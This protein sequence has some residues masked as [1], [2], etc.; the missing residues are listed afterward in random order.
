MR[1]TVAYLRVSSKL[2]TDGNGLDQQ[3]IGIMAWAATSG[4]EIDEWITETATGTTGQREEISDILKRAINGEI[5]CLVIDRMDRL[6]RLLM[7]SETLY[8]S[9]KEAGVEVVLVNQN[10]DDTPMGVAMRQV[11]GVFSE[12]QRSEWLG[13]MRQC[14][15]AAASKRGKFK[16][17]NTP[18]GYVV[19]RAGELAIDPVGATVVRLC[20]QLRKQGKTLVEIQ[21]ALT[22]RRLLTTAGTPIGLGQICKILKREAAYRGIAAFG[23]SQVEV[24]VQVLHPAILE[25]DPPMHVVS[26]RPSN[27][28]VI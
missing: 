7:V 22:A 18:Y 12:L 16:G 24:G 5:G 26:S 9:F 1:K 13:R 2:Q 23:N 28:Q 4:A 6:G 15:V 27:C 14:K 20:Y 17:G 21:S 3:R 25:G 8:T 11:A 19:M 10:L